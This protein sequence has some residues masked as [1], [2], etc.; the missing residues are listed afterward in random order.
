MLVVSLL[1]LLSGRVFATPAGPG[2]WHSAL[3]TTRK[4][5]RPSQPPGFIE[6]FVSSLR[7][8]AARRCIYSGALCGR[9]QRLGGGAAG[10]QR[11]CG[12]VHAAGAVR[13]R[14]EAKALDGGGGEE[15]APLV[16]RTA[17]NAFVTWVVPRALGQ[18][19]RPRMLGV[20]GAAW[21]SR[22]LPGGM[23][24]A[25]ETHSRPALSLGLLC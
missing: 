20:A 17:S 23:L 8:R 13:A 14:G 5:V 2:A 25:A 21:R 7:G 3:L 12:A 22:H 4:W 9:R 1:Q 6:S 10:A 16:S 19:L 15:V 18:G 11:V 24:P